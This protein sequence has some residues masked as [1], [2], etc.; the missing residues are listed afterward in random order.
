MSMNRRLVLAAAA[1][2]PFAQLARAQSRYPERPIKIIVPFP[3]GGQTDAAARIYAQK[4]EGLIGQPLVVENRPG[5]STLIGTEAVAKSAPDAYTLLLNMTALV[6]NPILLPNVQYDPFKDFV[7]VARLYS[8]TGIWAVPSTGPK[9]LAEFIRLA[10]A[11]PKPLS[12]ATTG[13]ASSSHYFGEVLAQSGGFQLNHVPY[14]GEAP[15]IPDLLSGRVDAAVISGQTALTYAKDG[16]IRVLA[17][18]GATRLKMLPDLPTFEEQGVGGLSLE[19]FCGMFAPA[20]TPSAIVERLND[21]FNKVMVMPDVQ[22]RIAGL[23]LDPPTPTTTAQF[24]AVMRKAHS[25][26]IE[27]KKR[28]EIRF[29]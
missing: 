18:T 25:E 17:T 5:A 24:S 7:P 20:G 6:T 14:K 15:I 2:A 29:E 11:A 3:A 8:L 21:A 1:A 10:K 22:Q 4:I 27:I 16:R 23:G 26:W 28:S 19:S 13:H 9:T 12:F